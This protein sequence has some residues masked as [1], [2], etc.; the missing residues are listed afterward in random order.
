MGATL[1]C[2]GEFGFSGLSVE[3][4]CSRLGAERSH[5]YRS[6]RNEKDAFV[7]AFDWKGNQLADRA[8]GLLRQEGP[9]EHRLRRVLEALAGL[10]AD[11]NALSRALFMEVHQA[12]HEAS[13]RRR[14][15][16]ERLAEALD[17]AGREGPVDFP[18]PP[19]AG[20][21]YVHVIDQAV[22][23][24]LLDGSPGDFADAVP[25]LAS[26]IFQAFSGG[27]SDATRQGT[28]SRQ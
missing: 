7:A 11:R 9:V 16:I 1:L 22:V 13:A 27:D 28:V 8:I 26:L 6:F 15:I 20:E 25:D 4:I 3:R 2:A 12:G 19:L 23:R 24:A 5:F 14:Q 18:P 21:F 10:I 17:Q